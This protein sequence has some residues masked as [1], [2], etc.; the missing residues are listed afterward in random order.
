MKH[1]A[2]GWSVF[3][4]GLYMASEGLLLMVAPNFL[5]GLLQVPLAVD[6]WPRVVG[7][8]LVVLGT[9]YTFAFSREDL[10]FF[11]LSGFVR[12]AQFLFFGWLFLTHQI[13][14]I[15]LGTSGLEALAGAVT[16]GL[17]TRKSR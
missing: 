3:I 7:L 1:T 4:F 11:R 8:A 9:Y 2:A 14:P 16:L 6:A 5:L 10:G 13:Q 15:L 12:L 17:L